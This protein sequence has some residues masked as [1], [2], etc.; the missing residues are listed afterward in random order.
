[1]D[2][3][4]SKIRKTINEYLR[5][6]DHICPVE[7]AVLF[8]SH[9]SG[10]VRERSDIDLAIFS[11]KINAHNRLKFMTVF[12]TKIGKYKLDLQ[13]LAFTF[14]DYLDDSNDFIANEIKRKGIEIYSRN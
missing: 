10:C 1:M 6:V 4:S 3:V 2:R 5:E 7:K 11:K 13:P 9:A 8:G 12:L 14:D